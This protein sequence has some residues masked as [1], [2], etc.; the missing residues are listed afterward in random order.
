M[1]EIHILGIEIKFKNNCKAT[2]FGI[3]CIMSKAIIETKNQLLRL[4]HLLVSTC[5][6]AGTLNFE[7]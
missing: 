1:K 5:E 2:L 3:K 7:H 6:T 4:Y